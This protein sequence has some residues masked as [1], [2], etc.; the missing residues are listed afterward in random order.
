MTDFL[1]SAAWLLSSA[2]GVLPVVMRSAGLAWTAPGWGM[3]GISWRVR[4]GLAAVLS[5]VVG[6]SV[7]F[8]LRPAE[9]LSAGPGWAVLVGSSLVELAIGAAL[10]F[11]AALVV[12]AARQAGD[13]IGAQA[14]L[15]VASL[16]DPEAG[17]G[18]TPVG[19]LYALVALALFLVFDGPLALV[20]ALA[21]SFQAV[22]PALTWTSPSSEL[23]RTVFERIGWALGLAVSAAAPAALAVAM[24]GLAVGWMAR[25]EGGPLLGG[26][27]WP[28][29]SAV[30]VVAVWLGLGS[31]A[32]AVSGA[33][34]QWLSVLEG[35]L[36]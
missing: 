30:G 29:R 32:V 6:P 21:G 23:A 8:P 1:P 27:V 24:A 5:L 36:F 19:H 13:L 31:L 18:A 33:W 10:G 14:G 16:L 4:L 17:E 26:M 7:G 15:S 34:R 35:S 22:P 9:S 3:P 11:S 2:R 20:D 12:M 28:V 25:S